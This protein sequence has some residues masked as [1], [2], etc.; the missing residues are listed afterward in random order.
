MTIRIRR[1]EKGQSLIV[2]TLLLFAFF[3]MLALVLDGGMTYWQRRNA[4]NAADA[5]ALAGADWL[6]KTK[7]TIAAELIAEEYA[8]DRNGATTAAAQA[9]LMNPGGIVTVNT[10]IN[11][12]SFFARL[13][14][15]N[16]IDAPAYAKAGCAPPE[17]VAVM[18]VAWSCRA[19]VG[20]DPDQSPCVVNKI[21]A[22]EGDNNVCSWDEGDPMYII[23]DSE[24]IEVEV[25]CLDE[26][27][28][29]VGAVDCDV[30]GDG[31]D[32]LNLLTGGDRS[33]LDLNGGGGGASELKDW[34]EGDY[35]DLFIRPHTW[36]PVQTGVTGSVY[37][38][39][40]D[41]I[42]GKRVVMPVF[43]DYC[44]EGAPHQ[45]G[46]SDL[47]TIADPPDNVND[48]VVG[49]DPQDYFHIITFS[50]WVTTCVDS[51]SHKGCPV[52]EVLDGLLE[53]AEWKTGD[54]NSL[55]T[56]EGCFVE[57][58]V[59]G[60]GGEPGQGIDVGLYNVFLME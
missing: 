33:W 7:D 34:I 45:T 21:P 47:H 14:G 20:G 30:D 3:A 35:G 49:D 38:T 59:P 13:F 36:V 39:V 55:K 37:D 53:D 10:N 27:G 58:A 23:A 48:T 42:L 2:V 51:A 60:I 9:T 56:M 46:C 41:H 50:Y 12:Q 28:L 18:P 25:L 26:N 19:P 29:P 57:G 40:N 15:L 5:G 54:I 52:R 32:D 4:Q 22:Y 24:K 11:F 8:R 43:D 31:D 1:L 17:G 6:C 44:P 16:F